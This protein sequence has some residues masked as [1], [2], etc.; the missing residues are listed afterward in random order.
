MYTMYIMYIVYIMYTMYTMYTMYRLDTIG[1]Y[2]H[3]AHA[4][5][6]FDSP[7]TAHPDLSA[8]QEH[9]ASAFSPWV[10]RRQSSAQA[11]LMPV[12]QRSL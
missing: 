7:L 10:R 2:S 12:R 5:Q 8:R 11:E 1:S 6:G 9:V 4:W 3:F